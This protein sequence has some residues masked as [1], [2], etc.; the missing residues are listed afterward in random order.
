MEVDPRHATALSD[1]LHE[2][3]MS[4]GVFSNQVAV[5]LLPGPR[6][7]YMRSVGCQELM[8]EREPLTAHEY[9]RFRRT[10]HRAKLDARAHMD[11]R[12]KLP[13]IEYWECDRFAYPGEQRQ[14]TGWRC[15]PG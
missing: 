13:H 11:Q 8:D 15:S 4:L 1:L 10:W 12:W 2:T 3:S 9:E 5:L 14:E 7:L 6:Y